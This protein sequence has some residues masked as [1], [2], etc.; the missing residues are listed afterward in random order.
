M[1]MR[2]FCSH[3]FNVYHSI[4]LI[5]NRN[6]QKVKGFRGICTLWRQ[7]YMV[8]LKSRQRTRTYRC[9]LRFLHCHRCCPRRIGP[10]LQLNKSPPM[11]TEASSK[12]SCWLALAI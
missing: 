9:G 2:T 3:V 8:L 10:H 7:R 12:V 6:K 5:Q 4:G 1:D 11:Q